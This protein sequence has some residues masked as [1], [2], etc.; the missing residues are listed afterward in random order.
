MTLFF[1]VGGIWSATAPISGAVIASGVVS[2]ER[3]RQTVQHLE[4]GI[5]REIKVREGQRVR[6][7]D[8][9]VVLERV[10][11]EAEAGARMSRYRTFVAVEARLQAEHAGM[12][13]VA[14]DHPALADRNNREVR[15]A[16]QAQRNQFEARRES[17]V[18]RRAILRQRIAQ[19]A[20]QVEG[21]E[22]QLKGTKQQSA[23]ISEEI[24]AVRTLYDKG[25]A[26]KPRLLALRRERAKLLGTQGEL[27]ARI[28]RTRQAIG[29]T[30]LQI[31]NLKIERIEEID[32]RLSDVIAK[33]TE[34]EKEMRASMDRLRRTQ[35]HAPVSGT[36]LGL[37]FKTTG[38]VIGPGQP[39]LDLVPVKGNF[40]IEARIKPNDIDEIR[41]GQSAYVVFPSF[42]Q[43]NLKRIKGVV[44]RYS[45][46]ALEDKR[47][48]ERYYS[49]RVVVDRQHLKAVAPEIKLSPGMPAEVFI[50]TQERT[51]LE[52][53]LQ[54][55]LIT[56]E[57]AFRET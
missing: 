32:S 7:G 27:V 37:R 15:A 25:L 31:A 34:L 12:E 51:V 43:R 23:L 20:T 10:R 26:R 22:R 55:F 50:G 35:I 30:R 49:A 6:A 17:M 46:D 47:T 5:I 57:R 9:L 40:V 54:P 42:A 28:A 1:V 16:I 36:V 45:P 4:G 24:A 3:S 33:R 8:V 29:E 38:G 48:G 14:F 53:L 41:N 52:F 44:Q 19:L 21:L 56:L 18:S 13:R 39:I 2:P 11:A